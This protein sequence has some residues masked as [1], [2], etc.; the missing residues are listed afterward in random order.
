V[1]D[2][3]RYTMR[4]EDVVEHP[5]LSISA[6]TE[7]PTGHP[8]DSLSFEFRAAEG[9]EVYMIL[10]ADGEGN[11]LRDSTTQAEYEAIMEEAV[12]RYEPLRFARRWLMDSEHPTAQW[13]R[14]Y[15]R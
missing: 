15:N 11:D 7:P 5:V 2:R 4:V 8:A 14:E 3:P 13:W 9:G 10:L 1:S 6:V 12:W